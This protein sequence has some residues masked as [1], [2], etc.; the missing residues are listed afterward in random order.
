V[1]AAQTV[2][3]ADNCIAAVKRAWGRLDAGGRDAK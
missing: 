1:V 3:Q 2:E